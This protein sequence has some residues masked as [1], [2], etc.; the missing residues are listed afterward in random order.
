MIS[1]VSLSQKYDFADLREWALDILEKHSIADAAKFIS[2]FTAW[3][4]IKR[5]FIL[6][7]QCR[8]CKLLHCLENDWL[9]NIATGKVHALCYALDVAETYSELRS[10]HGKAYY[11]Q[12]K[13]S[14][15]FVLR[16]SNAGAIAA[17]EVGPLVDV[18]E[19]IPI[20]NGERKLR[21]QQ[22]FWS[23]SMLRH[24]PTYKHPD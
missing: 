6:A 17:E 23:L 3:E 10:F 20:L 8:C 14:N 22:G 13:G 7:T 2:K 19:V 15:F 12:L 21:L 9:Q 18:G 11:A 24:R 16:S 5:L 1:I 4:S